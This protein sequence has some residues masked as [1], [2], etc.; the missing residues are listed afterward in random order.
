M[1]LSAYSSQLY[2]VENC[3][4]TDCGPT[5]MEIFTLRWEMVPPELLRLKS[6]ALEK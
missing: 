5:H 2:E 1:E 6:H 4:S 3:E